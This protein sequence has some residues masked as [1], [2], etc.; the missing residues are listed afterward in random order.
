M[1]QSAAE[2]YRPQQDAARG[3][4][5]RQ[6]M[7]IPGMVG[8]KAHP[9]AHGFRR[10]DHHAIVDD[11]NQRARF[12]SWEGALV[13]D[14]P[15]LARGQGGDREWTRTNTDTPPGLYLSGELYRD[16]EKSTTGNG[17]AI[18]RAYGWLSIDLV[19]L[20][21]QESRWKRAGIMAH[22]G[23]TGLGWPGAWAPQQ[24]LLPT[25]GCIR[26]HNADLQRKVLPLLAKGRLFWSV[27]QEAPAG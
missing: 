4:T 14:L 23:G 16:Y 19:E 11:R 10:G 18:H 6:A 3:R 17:G 13:L 5:Q 26:M 27:Y 15:A 22:G 21:A 25:F 20:E 9:D 8:P 12:F 24:P 1:T 7:A 2:R